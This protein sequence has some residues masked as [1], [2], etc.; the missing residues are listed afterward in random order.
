MPKH[1]NSS[2]QG[3]ALLLAFPALQSCSVFPQLIKHRDALTPE[4][5]M[6]LGEAYEAQGLKED[7]GHQYES[8][9][10][11][12]KKYIPALIARGNLAFENRNL[13]KAETYYRKVLRIDANHAGANNNMA[14]ICLARGRDLDQAE[15]FVQTALKEN[16]PLKPY[17]LETLAVIY[18]ETNRYPEARKA[19]DEAD[20]I[21][22]SNDAALCEQLLKTRK[23]IQTNP[24]LP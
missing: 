11:F 18:I 7:A 9:L 16:T 14:M 21:A 23:K 10:G 20:H 1:R 22:P 15:R 17:A 24:N 12:R 4:E 13:E 3:W 2:W 8:A 19:L 5:H 6:Q